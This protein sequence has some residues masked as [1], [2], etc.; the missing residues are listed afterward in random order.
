MGVVWLDRCWVK[1]SENVKFV[2]RKWKK[3]QKKGKSGEIVR[4]SGIVKKA[5]ERG[6]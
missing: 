1:Y 4:K 3:I 2:R 5:L 6:I